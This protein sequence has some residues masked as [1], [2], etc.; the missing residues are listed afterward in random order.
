MPSISALSAAHLP[1]L[2][3]IMHRNPFEIIDSPWGPIEA[4]RASTLATGT[5]GALSSV[6]DLVRS[7]S[8][9]AAARADAEQAR[10]ALLKDVHQRLDALSARCDAQASELAALKADARRRADDEA[11][12]ARFDEEP[13][14]LPPDIAEYQTRTPPSEIGDDTHQLGGELHSVAAKEEPALEDPDLEL[15]LED[16]EGDLPKELAPSTEPVPEPK[17]QVYQ[18]PVSI[19]LNEE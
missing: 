2:E 5:M 7:D 14:T 12:K 17:G 1:T 8:D 4:W 6:Y 10:V 15:E 16:S 3:E 11:R 19:S 18:Q 13:L 9:A